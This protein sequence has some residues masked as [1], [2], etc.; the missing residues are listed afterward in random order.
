MSDF[1]KSATR[2][3]TYLSCYLAGGLGNQLFQIF[4]TLAYGIQT[5]RAV[6]FPYSDVLTTGKHRP[7]YW[8]T[9]LSRLY[10]FTTQHER[11]SAIALDRFTLLR[12][13]DVTSFPYYDFSPLLQT[14]NAVLFYGYF[15]SYRYFDQYKETICNMIQITEQKKRVATEHAEALT[16]ADSREIT[17]SMHFRLGDYKTLQHCHPVL[18]IEYYRRALTQI[19]DTSSQSS[20]KTYKVLYFCEKEDNDE[21]LAMI[22]VL[23][24]EFSNMRWVKVDDSICDWKQMLLMSCCHHNIVANSTFSWWGAYFNEHPYKIVCY[25]GPWFGASLSHDTRD[26]CPPDWKKIEYSN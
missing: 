25:P 5:S 24:P 8:H 12:E 16:T 3:T 17:I 2:T 4:T 6:V 18:P 20:N 26:L 21:I 19:F 10:A 23:T 15:Q 14:N 13:S 1:T 22:R 7:T 11:Y 9:F